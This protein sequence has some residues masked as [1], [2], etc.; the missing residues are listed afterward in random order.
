MALA[1][2]VT[3]HKAAKV[4]ALLLDNTLLGIITRPTYLAQELV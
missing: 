1:A 2:F 4:L 3:H